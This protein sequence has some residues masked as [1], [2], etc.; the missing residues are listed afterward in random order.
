M[1]ETVNSRPNS[2]DPV[3]CYVREPWAYFTVLNL[4]AQGG[5]GWHKRPYQ[6]NSSPPYEPPGIIFKLAYDG[7]FETPSDFAETISVEDINAGKIAWVSASRWGDGE[8]MAIR[9]GTTL[10]EFKRL[11]KLA[12][13]KIY[14]EKEMA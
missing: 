13:G 10:S 9:A 14:E 2:S 7:S 12:G 4:K 8:A 6:Y 11:I 3:L 5:D 1:T